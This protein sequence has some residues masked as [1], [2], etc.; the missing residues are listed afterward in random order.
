MKINKILSIFAIGI[1]I[2][3]CS[4]LENINDN[5]NSAAEV[6]PQA[7]LPNIC[8]DA[9]DRGYTGG[10]KKKKNPVNHS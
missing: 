7:I 9:F 4:N 10:K 5:P 3:S 8:Q 1:T 2:A 6:N